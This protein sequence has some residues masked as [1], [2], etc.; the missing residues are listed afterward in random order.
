[1]FTLKKKNKAIGLH[2]HTMYGNTEKPAHDLE[3][4]QI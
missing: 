4:W 1:M 3:Y 2:R